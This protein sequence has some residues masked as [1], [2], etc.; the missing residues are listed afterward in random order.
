MDL[1]ID[2]N[3]L[4]FYFAVDETVAKKD[5]LTS[6]SPDKPHDYDGNDSDMEVLE[7]EFT[8]DEDDGEINSLTPSA[9]EP[10][11]TDEDEN[12]VPEGDD[13]SPIK[14]KDKGNPKLNK[15]GDSKPQAAKNQKRK[16]SKP[17]LQPQKF[18]TANQK[19]TQAAKIF[20]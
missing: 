13:R 19:K 5:D 18:E 1:K 9:F 17:E 10:P 12:Q 14:K 6:D 8:D 4:T 11:P 15:R 20:G 7:G 16:K 2:K 3:K